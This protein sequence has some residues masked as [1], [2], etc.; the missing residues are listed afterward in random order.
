MIIFLG[1]L[2][3][4]KEGLEQPVS[5]MLPQ[6]QSM[7]PVLDY[8]RSVKNDA[9]QVWSTDSQATAAMVPLQIHGKNA[10][11]KAFFEPSAKQR[12]FRRLYR[13]EKHVGLVAC[14]L[15]F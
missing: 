15:Q 3:G 6:T 14:L 4:L 12:C 9:Y 13:S 8:I 11:R 5:S 10:E 7:K 2:L 1:W